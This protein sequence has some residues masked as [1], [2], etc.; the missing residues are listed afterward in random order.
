MYILLIQTVKLIVLLVVLTSQ[1][2]LTQKNYTFHNWRSY[3]TPFSY[4]NKLWYTLY[5][6]KSRLVLT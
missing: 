2:E 4:F 5:L 3:D 6:F 1:I